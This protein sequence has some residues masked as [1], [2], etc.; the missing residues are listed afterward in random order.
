MDVENNSFY[1]RIISIQATGE[2]QVVYRPV[3]TSTSFLASGRPCLGGVNN[4]NG[5]NVSV[6][7]HVNGA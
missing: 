7:F 5:L 2:I 6:N 1:K 4:A 3:R